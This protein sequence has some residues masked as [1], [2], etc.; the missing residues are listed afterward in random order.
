[1]GSFLSVKNHRQKKINKSEF[2]GLISWFPF[3]GTSKL[4]FVGMSARLK[5]GPFSGD[6]IFVRF[7]RDLQGI[8]NHMEVGIT[9]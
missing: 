7:F 5:R 2:G 6:G 4:H 1:M 8:K 9:I 3:S